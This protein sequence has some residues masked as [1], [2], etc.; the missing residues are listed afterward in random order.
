MRQQAEI[1]LKR[2]TDN[3]ELLAIDDRF[4]VVQKSDFH[5]HIIHNESQRKWNYWPTSNKF[6]EV[7]QGK[8]SVGIMQFK[9]MIEAI[10][11]ELGE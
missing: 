3:L 7:K 1:N 6:Q 2:N 11:N 4:S 9:S 5:W 8:A 10:L